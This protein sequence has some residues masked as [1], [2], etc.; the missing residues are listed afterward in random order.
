MADAEDLDLSREV[1]ARAQEV[2]SYL[3][4]KDKLGALVASLQNPPVTTKDSSIKDKNSAAVEQV[5]AVVGDND[6]AALVGGLDMDSCDTLMKYLY[7]IMG[8]VDKGINYAILLKLHAAVSEKA[9][10]GCV[11]RSLTDRK[12]V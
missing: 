7:K 2:A 8:R 1:D 10:V 3:K 9:G 12:Q 6:V 11:L 5:L 4:R